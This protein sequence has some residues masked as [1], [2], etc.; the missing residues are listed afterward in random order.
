[1]FFFP[2]R[3]LKKIEDSVTKFQAA[4]NALSIGFI[5]TDQQGEIETINIA[6]K[7]L[8]CADAPNL[9]TSLTDPKIIALTCDINLIANNLSGVFDIKTHIQKVLSD[10]KSFTIHSL[11]YKN[12]FLNISI[13]P[14]FSIGKKGKIT[15]EFIGT[16]ILIEDMTEQKIIERSKDD[17][18][19]IASHELKTPLTIIKGNS[20]IIKK[21]YSEKDN[22]FNQIINDIHESS[23][24]MIEI[25]NDFLDISRMEQGKIQF[26]KQILDIEELI[27]K[28]VSGFMEFA[29]SKKLYLDFK[30][31]AKIPPV[32][33]DEAKVKQVFINLLD[34]AL[35]FTDRGGVTVSLTQDDRF[36]KV[37]IK[38]TGCGIT[39]SNQKLIFRKFQL[40]SDDILSRSSA[41]ST[42]VGLYIAK[43]MVER[44]GGQIK[45]VESRLKQGSIFE[46]TLPLT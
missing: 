4:I 13:S 39:P 45:L 14:V 37:T 30:K 6:A 24:N 12:L 31:P 1:M 35:K 36:A 19:S 11:N 17:F 2:D 7:D 18:F 28:T 38:D 33:A 22:R 41:K 16:V 43:F 20:E 15:L 44:M 5:I 40:A 23:E 32:L 25:V 34:N 3:N 27:S 9:K 26:K 21:Y 8:L 10:R 29:S 42:G 46:F